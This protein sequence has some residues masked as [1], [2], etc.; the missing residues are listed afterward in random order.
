M[1]VILKEE[2]LKKL[3]NSFYTD[4]KDIKFSSKNVKATLTLEFKN[5][6]TLRKEAPT[7]LFTAP[8]LPNEA[9]V[10]ALATTKFDK[11]T[12][13]EKE[14]EERATGAMARGEA[15]RNLRIIG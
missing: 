5:I 6:T 3:I 11:L 9:D 1:E 4:V 7:S 2:D 10:N 15:R 8:A 14:D 13:E 12:E